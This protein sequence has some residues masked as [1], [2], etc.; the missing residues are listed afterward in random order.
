MYSMATDLNFVSITKL[1]RI[2]MKAN[3]Q[4]N[5][6][7]QIMSE[8]KRNRNLK[9]WKGAI[10]AQGK[11]KIGEKRMKVKHRQMWTRMKN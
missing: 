6:S 4:I 1:F 5:I 2:S 10:S 8:V 11:D 7:R 9:R 3:S